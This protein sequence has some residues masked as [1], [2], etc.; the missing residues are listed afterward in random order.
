MT[1]EVYTYI[2]L[3]CRIN[4]LLLKESFNCGEIERETTVQKF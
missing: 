2:I 3:N 1:R 4:N